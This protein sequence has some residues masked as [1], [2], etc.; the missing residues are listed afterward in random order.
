MALLGMPGGC[1]QPNPLQLQAN[2]DS[3]HYTPTS[4]QFNS[5]STHSNSTKSPLSS[6]PNPLQLQA[7]SDSTHYT[8]TSTALNS[9]STQRNS[10]PTHSKSTPFNSVQIHCNSTPTCDFGLSLFG[11]SVR[12]SSSLSLSRFPFPASSLNFGRLQC[13][14]LHVWA[15]AAPLEDSPCFRGFLSQGPRRALKP[16]GTF[17]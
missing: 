2:S 9:N 7:N 6:Q 11:L 5:N 12:P 13:I 14:G 4:T 17:L 15:P 10:N 16:H 3:T 1:S 8:P